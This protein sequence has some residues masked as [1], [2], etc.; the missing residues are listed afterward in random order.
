MALGH[1]GYLNNPCKSKQALLLQYRLCCY[2]I[3]RHM[4]KLNSSPHRICPPLL[5][6]VPLLLLLSCCSQA[7][8]GDSEG[9][10]GGS[11]GTR[12]QR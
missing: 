4:G 1:V 11:R 7:F 8:Q 9:E 2:N 10:Y 3:T 12:A 6:A 5:M